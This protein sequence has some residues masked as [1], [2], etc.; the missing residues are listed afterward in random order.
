MEIVLHNLD[1]LLIISLIVDKNTSNILF[2]VE[3]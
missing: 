2:L 3:F 1:Y